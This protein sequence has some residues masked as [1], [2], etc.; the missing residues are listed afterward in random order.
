[1]NKHDD[2]DS[3]DIKSQNVLNTA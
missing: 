2:D 3:K 1:V